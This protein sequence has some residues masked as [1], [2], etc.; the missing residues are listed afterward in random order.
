MKSRA[1]VLGGNRF[2]GRHLVLALL[3]QGYEVTL[4]NRGRVDD[5]LGSRV[6][7]IQADRSKEAD[8]KKVLSGGKSWDLVFDQICFTATEATAIC[9]ILRGKTGRMVFTSSQSV[10]GD[11]LKIPEST[12]DPFTYHYEKEVTAAESYAEAKR[13]SETAFAKFPEMNPLMMRM[14]LVIGTDDY[15]GRFAWHIDRCLREKS[16]FFPNPQARLGFV[17]SDFAGSALLAVAKSKLSGP[18]NCANPGDIQLSEF[19]R[20]VESATKKQYIK[21]DV[22]DS[23]NHSP[24]GADQDWTMSLEKLSSGGIVLPSLSEWLP[25]LVQEEAAAREKI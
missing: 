16:I 11:G 22:A 3:E 7:R 24:Y 10:Y 12:F 21:A 9:E 23:E 19:M 6:E 1:L 18:V 5:H 14:P 13:Q 2:F 20:L 25:K 17:R 15:T 4:L 8:L